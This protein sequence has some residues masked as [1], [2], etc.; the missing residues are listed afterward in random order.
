MQSGAGIRIYSQLTPGHG[1]PIR[2]R[3]PKRHKPVGMEQGF[4]QGLRRAGI[5]REYPSGLNG[6]KESGL[7]VLTG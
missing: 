2:P 7:G 4:V 6:T 1:P 3:Q 5:L